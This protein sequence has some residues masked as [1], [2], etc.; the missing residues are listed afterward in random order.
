GGEHEIARIEP[1]RGHGA[2]EPVMERLI[3][4]PA[5][6]QHEERQGQ[7]GGD[8][9]VAL[10]NSGVFIV[11]AMIMGG[12]MWIAHGALVAGLLDGLE[13]MP[14]FATRY[15]SALGRQVDRGGFDALHPKQRLFHA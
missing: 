9:D 12:R 14:N 3:D 7:Y 8:N 4:M 2:H 11:M 10:E 5:H 13:Q 6:L 1:L 15:G